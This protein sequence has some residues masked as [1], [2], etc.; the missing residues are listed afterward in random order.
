MKFVGFMSTK[1]AE[2]KNQTSSPDLSHLVEIKAGDT[3][4]LL[5]HRIYGDPAYYLQVARFNGLK[6]VNRLTAGARL[7]FPPLA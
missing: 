2:A 6:D 4:P 7:H 5:C 3:L 1:E